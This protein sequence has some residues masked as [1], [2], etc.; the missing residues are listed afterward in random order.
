MK[1]VVMDMNAVKQVMEKAAWS[2]ACAEMQRQI[3]AQIA[4]SFATVRGG[5]LDIQTLNWA[6]G[7]PPFT[8][9]G[10]EVVWE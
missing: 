7:Q 4:P 3:N 5:F 9:P 8:I 6:Q 2:A 10:Y 1:R